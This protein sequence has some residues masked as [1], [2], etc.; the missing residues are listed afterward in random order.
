TVLAFEPNKA[1]H[2]D[3]LRERLRPAEVVELPDDSGIDQPELTG[4][5]S[6]LLRGIST[7]Y[8]A[9][10]TI[11]RSGPSVIDALQRHLQLASA[12]VEE[13]GIPESIDG[14][15]LLPISS[16]WSI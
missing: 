9:V 6:E 1:E 12:R 15:V 10:T 5:L 11:N 8:V 3:T 16:T 7:R 14:P 13:L 2:V 4:A